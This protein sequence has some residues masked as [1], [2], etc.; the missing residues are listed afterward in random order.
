MIIIHFLAKEIMKEGGLKQ[1]HWL[2]MR[3]IH[4]WMD[5]EETLANT[6]LI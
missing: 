2:K 6:G 4:H 5:L 3:K 1:S